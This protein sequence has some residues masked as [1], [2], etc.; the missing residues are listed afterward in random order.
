MRTRWLISAGALS[1]IL[2]GVLRMGPKTLFLSGL[3]FQI[4]RGP[5]EVRNTEDTTI[6]RFV[7]QTP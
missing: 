7:G 5:I 2:D 6:T 1:R 4:G 3:H